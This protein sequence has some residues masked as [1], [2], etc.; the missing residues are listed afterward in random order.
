MKCVVL[1]F[2]LEGRWCLSDGAVFGEANQASNFKVHSGKRRKKTR[3]K[4]RETTTVG[5]FQV[6]G[7]YQICL[8]EIVLFVSSTS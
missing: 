7:P 1:G 3:E 8:A 5:Y 2:L 4:R 6:L